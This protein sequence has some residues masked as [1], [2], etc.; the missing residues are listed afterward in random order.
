MAKVTI[1]SSR[2]R[3]ADG[4]VSRVGGRV[5]L[6]VWAPIELGR[7]GTDGCRR[8]TGLDARRSRQ[9]PRERC[10][11][12]VG[13]CTAVA[14]PALEQRNGRWKPVEGPDEVGRVWCSVRYNQ[15]Q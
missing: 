7:C 8:D 6:C 10:A 9:L 4:M 12:A 5:G 14:H 2:S 13:W 3:R 1:R 11:R 15:A